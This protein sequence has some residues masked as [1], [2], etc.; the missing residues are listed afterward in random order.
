MLSLFRYRE[1]IRDLVLKDLF[2][3]LCGRVLQRIYGA[4]GST[5]AMLF[6]TSVLGQ[7]TFCIIALPFGSSDD[8]RFVCDYE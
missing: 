4:L 7:V 2:R 3:R 6:G 1:L 8:G 5:S